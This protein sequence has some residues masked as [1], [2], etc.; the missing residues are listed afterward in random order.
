MADQWQRRG[1]SQS[2]CHVN[3]S[4]TIQSLTLS[5][6]AHNETTRARYALSAC[7]SSPLT[8]ACL[9]SMAAAAGVIMAP[10]QVGGCKRPKWHTL[11]DAQTRLP[12]AWFG[13]HN[14]SCSP[15]ALWP[16][17]SSAD[18][19]FPVR[20]LSKSAGKQRAQA[21]VV[22]HLLRRSQNGLVF[23]LPAGGMLLGGVV[24]M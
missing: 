17:T 10:R 24:W 13:F 4:A 15:P 3:M 20:S 22:A 8:L 5:P 7:C 6:L 12:Y 19:C 18:S 14:R 2:N 16:C 21:T 23:V 1:S 11:T 9:E